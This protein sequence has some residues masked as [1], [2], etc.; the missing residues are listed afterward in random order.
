MFKN[1]AG[2]QNYFSR[3]SSVLMNDYNLAGSNFTLHDKVNWMT[4]IMQQL[5]DA[6]GAAVTLSN[7]LSTNEGVCAMQTPTKAVKCKILQCA[8][9]YIHLCVRVHTPV[10]IRVHVHTHVHTCAH[11]HAPTCTHLLIGDPHALTDLLR[12]FVSP[13]LIGDFTRM[14]RELGPQ[15]R[16]IN[17]LESIS[18]VEGRPIK[19]NQEMILRLVWMND[20][21]RQNTTLNVFERR[22]GK[23]K[24]FV[25]SISELHQRIIT[26]G[27]R[28][29][30]CTP[31]RT[32]VTPHTRQ[33]TFL[34]VC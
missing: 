1:N 12:K 30:N 19:S 25:R 13:E 29:R 6:L 9:P 10:H 28:I 24:Y 33:A 15:E 7:V 4:I 27:S 22:G 14:I 2:S 23:Y 17:F 34:W 26:E 3:R 16:L 5:D 32:Y 11:A 21:A 18:D 20:D 31:C 8:H